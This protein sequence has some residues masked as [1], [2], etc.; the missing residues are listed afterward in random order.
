MKLLKNFL[1]KLSN[2]KAI[3]QIN[4]NMSILIIKKILKETKFQNEKC[5]LKYGYKVFSQQDEDGIID[6]I[7]KRIGPGSKKFIEMGLETGVECN[8]ANLLFQDWSGLWV[9]ANKQNIEGIK[10]NFSKFL[11]TSLKVHSDKIT[12]NNVNQILSKYFKIGFEIDLLSIDIGVHTFHVLKMIEA[13]NPRVIVTEYNAKYGPIID[14]TVEYNQDADWDNSDYFGASLHAFEKMMKNKNYY[15]VGCNITGVNAFF[16]RKDQLKDKFEENF[17]S[18][19]HFMDGRYWLK[20]AFDKNYKT[21]I[22]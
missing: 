13:V 2:K 21:R 14:W 16:V 17:S 9:E 11:D 15:L 7:F 6:E 20:K 19:H 5:L 18:E 8:T 10:K 4:R 3:D 22:I 1:L 12:T